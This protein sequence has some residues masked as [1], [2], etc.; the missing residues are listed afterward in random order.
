MCWLRGTGI[1][2][3]NNEN[4]IRTH[5]SL[6][7]S[8]PLRHQHSLLPAQLRRSHITGQVHIAD[9]DAG[10]ARSLSRA[11]RWRNVHSCSVDSTKI[12]DDQRPMVDYTVANTG[13]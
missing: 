5:C 3:S 13:G 1:E 6:Y 2:V 10:L 4:G 9:D 7:A 12:P 8:K 11:T